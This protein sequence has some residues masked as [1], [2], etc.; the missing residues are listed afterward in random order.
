LPAKRT[1]TAQTVKCGGFHDL[2]AV[3]RPDLTT[4][5]ANM[6]LSSELHPLQLGNQQFQMFDFRFVRGQLGQLLMRE[7]KLLVLGILRASGSS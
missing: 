7:N 1:P 6:V 5:L 2:P 4:L 3:S